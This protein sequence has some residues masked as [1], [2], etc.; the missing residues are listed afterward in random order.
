MVQLVYTRVSM[1][2]QSTQRQV[3]LLAEAGLVAVEDEVRFFSDLASSSQVSALQ[4]PGFLELAGYAR[5][6]DTVTVAELYRLC[7]DVADVLAVRAWCQEHDVRLRVL[8][9]ALSAITDLA[10]ADATTTMLV[11]VLVSVGQFQRDLQNEM[12]RGGLAAARA[13]YVRSARR[14]QVGVLGRREEVRRAYQD[15]ASII[16]LSRTHG[17]SRAAIRA[18]IADLV[19]NQPKEFE[20]V[21]PGDDEADAEALRAQPFLVKMPG[22]IVRHLL[23][24][25]A[26]GDVLS[27]VERQALAEAPRV[28]RGQGVSVHVTAAYDVHRALAAAAV[29]LRRPGASQ[30][31]RKAME[32]YTERIYGGDFH[33]RR[34]AREREQ[35]L[36]GF[37]PVPNWA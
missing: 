32:V 27:D 31:E 3:N 33:A 11:N 4:R 20:Q 7:R 25:D 24:V 18:A 36:T 17:V 21:G 12:T 16:S 15:G 23:E 9:G 13:T 37:R 5:A 28:Q 22:K 34:A 10:G 1:D 35:E 2:E 8:S 14:P 29:A 26:E 30:T 6:G 19:A